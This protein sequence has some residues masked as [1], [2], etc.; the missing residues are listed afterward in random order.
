[1][2][3]GY[4]QEQLDYAISLFLFH[5]NFLDNKQQ[6]RE[7]IRYN[8]TGLLL[9][10]ICCFIFFLY[11]CYRWRGFILIT[12]ALY[13][14]RRYSITLFYYFLSLLFVNTVLRCSTIQTNIQNCSKHKINTYCVIIKLFLN[15]KYNFVPWTWHWTFIFRYLPWNG[16]VSFR[17]LHVF[18]SIAAERITLDIC[19]LI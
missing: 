9:L 3:T 5:C 2:N 16:S 15:G 19:N 4:L 18:F 11:T 6:T 1:M 14:F 10:Y 7:F 17:I 12:T 8:E 13:S